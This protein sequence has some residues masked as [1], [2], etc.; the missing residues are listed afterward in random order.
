[1]IK[2]IVSDLDGT[3]LTRY[4]TIPKANV[5]AILA[6]QAAG[7]KVALATGRGFETSKQF[8]QPLGLD[9]YEGFMIVNNGQRVYEAQSLNNV[10]HGFITPDQSRQVFALAKAS[11][12]QLI[13]DG[14]S[15]LA[16]YSPKE[17]EIY[18]DVYRLLI[19]VLPY[20]RPLLHRIHIF[21]L[22]GFLRTQKVTILREVDDIVEAYDKM[23]LAQMK[24][25]LDRCEADLKRLLNVEFE[26]MRVS[27]NWID[28]APKGITKITGIRDVMQRLGLHEDEVL[29]IGDSENDITMLRAFKHSVAMGNASDAIKANARFITKSNRECGVAEAIYTHALKREHFISK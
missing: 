12:V 27:S 25:Q 5:D 3:L 20:F 4:K 21:A 7:I 17:L 8:I 15:G 2:L 29:V 14:E 22:F 1:M 11:N 9:R 19:R 16:F 13:L 18:R 24:A 6:A 26:V 23:G 28:V 10:T